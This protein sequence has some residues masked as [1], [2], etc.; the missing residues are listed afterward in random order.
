[1][2]LIFGP[3]G[4]GKSMQGK[5]LAA[6]N[7]WTWLSAGQ[8]LRDEHN[9]ELLSQMQKGELIDPEIVNGVVAKALLKAGSEKTVIL[10]GYPRML[11]QAKYLVDSQPEHGKSIKFV[12]VLDVPRDTVTTRLL[13][14]SRIDD[15]VDAINHRL[16]QYQ[17]DIP[18]VLEFLAKNGIEIV[19]I[20]GDD[21]IGRVHDN[22][23][24]KLN[25][26]KLI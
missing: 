19:H 17:S 8:L 24:N 10:D 18:E 1:M 9:P 7:G 13:K 21:T 3:T 12:I 14:R 16:D 6:R 22:I 5:L 4:S 20:D 23:I 26:L 15:N 2:I 25:E 11:E